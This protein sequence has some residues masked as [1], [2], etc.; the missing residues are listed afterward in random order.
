M[1]A[2]AGKLRLRRLAGIAQIVQHDRAERRLRP[3]APAGIDRIIVD[4]N[5]ARARGLAGLGEPFGAVDR[6]QPGRIA[7]FRAGQQIFFDPLRRRMLDQVLDREY[8]RI[9]L[10]AHLHRIAAVD[11]DRGAVTEHD[12]RAGRSGEAGEKSK[13]LGAGRH[14]FVLVAV[15]A[16]HD[17]TVE[18]A[19]LQFG[20]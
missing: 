9:D 5:K 6:V 13:P 20:A 1:D 8:R 16:R 19:A 12:G 7:E 2:D 11:K 14:I 10:L 3:V 18:A 17:K 15:G 4:R